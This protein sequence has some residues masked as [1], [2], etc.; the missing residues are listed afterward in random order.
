MSPSII[1][2]YIPAHNQQLFESLPD[3]AFIR[4]NQL[5]MMQLV[6]FSASTLWRMVNR[7]E[8]PL[9]VK[10][11]GQIT[12]WRV[13]DIRLWLNDPSRYRRVGEAA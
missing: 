11:S 7:G 3:S 8:F 13:G 6:P 1:K 2:S 4:Q 5:L 9:P 10:I 12:A